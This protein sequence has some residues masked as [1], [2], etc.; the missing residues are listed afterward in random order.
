MGAFQHLGS[1]FVTQSDVRAKAGQWVNVLYSDYGD[2]DEEI[3]MAPALLVHL[4]GYQAQ[5]FAVIAWGYRETDEEITSLAGAREEY[6]HMAAGL[7]GVVPSD[8]FQIVATETIESIVSEHAG[9]PLLDEEVPTEKGVHSVWRGSWYLRN[10]HG[11]RKGR[12]WKSTVV[13]HT[14]L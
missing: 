8:Y 6:D 12:L 4:F 11:S 2:D 14:I 13:T 3:P 5:E 7:E 10:Q 1:A 9:L